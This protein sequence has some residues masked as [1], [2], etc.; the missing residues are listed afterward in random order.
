[1]TYYQSLLLV[2]SLS[3]TGPCPPPTNPTNPIPCQ[4]TCLEAANALSNILSNSQFCPGPDTTGV[5]SQTLISY[6]SLC[7]Q[8]PTNNCLAAIKAEAVQCGFPLQADFTLYCSPNGAGFESDPCCTGNPITVSGLGPAAVAASLSMSLMTMPTS[9]AAGV[10]NGTTVNP[11]M[12]DGANGGGGVGGGGGTNPPQPLVIGLS[13]GAIFALIIITVVGI[14]YVSFRRKR[15]DQQ[16]TA[17]ASAAGGTLNNN[18]QMRREARERGGPLIVVNDK[19]GGLR[20]NN[21]IPPGGEILLMGD[22][23][24]NGNSVDR[25]AAYDN[26]NDLLL[27]AGNS[28]NRRS[29]SFI[30][31]GDEGNGNNKNNNLTSRTVESYYDDNVEY[32]DNNNNRNMASD[33]GVSRD[34][35]HTSVYTNVYPGTAPSNADDNDELYR[36]D[37]TMTGMTGV[38]SE[39]GGVGGGGGN[40]GTAD[41]LQLK[42]IHPYEASMDDE[43]TLRPGDIVTVTDLFD[44]GWGH[45]II[46]RNRGAFPLPCVA[47]LDSPEALAIS[48]AT[49]SSYSASTSSSPYNNN[50]KNN[51]SNLSRRISSLSRRD[52]E[53]TI[54]KYPS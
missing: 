54:N 21:T 11:P 3:P 20:S 29:L 45:G 1:M 9:N 44:D 18:A 49:G 28:A 51:S 39:G 23:K 46:G 47:A 13:I 31:Y 7:S 50:N 53:W 19:N 4:Q 17:A 36:R 48:S 30:A 27:E 40:G 33:V 43:L 52:S 38:T 16:V 10:D 15:K 25:Y 26:D 24:N 5:R 37:T 42:V 34:L 32:Y 35:G 2:N 8:L 6:N 41:L 22:V 12:T 14:L